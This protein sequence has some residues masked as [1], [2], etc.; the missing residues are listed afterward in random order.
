MELTKKE[1]LFVYRH[2]SALL[3]DEEANK[4][5]KRLEA[6]LTDNAEVDSEDEEQ[7]EHD[8]EFET[9]DPNALHN[10]KPARST[11]NNRI[12][13]EVA[14]DGCVELLVD[15]DSY[16]ITAIKR[17]GNDFSFYVDAADDDEQYWHNVTLQRIPRGWDDVISDGGKYDFE[18]D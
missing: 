2:V 18:E 16:A 17:V 1:A 13:F 12:E 4:L 9:I 8:E 3:L 10:L 14:S 6:F 5:T 7:E 11:A 15:G